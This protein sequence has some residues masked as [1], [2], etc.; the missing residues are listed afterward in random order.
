MNQAQEY[1]DEQKKVLETIKFET[2]KM[3][4]AE[5]DLTGDEEAF[6]KAKREAEERFNEQ[7]FQLN[8]QRLELGLDTLQEAF[9]GRA[10]SRLNRYL[11][12]RCGTPSTMVF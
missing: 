8:I 9:R 4:I 1:I 5:F 3:A 12:H 10:N 11:R 6:E 2:I 7:V